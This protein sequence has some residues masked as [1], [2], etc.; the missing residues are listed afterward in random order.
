MEER[1]LL[2]AIVLSVAILFAWQYF[3]PSPERERITPEE[4]QTAETYTA[5]AESDV[6]GPEDEDVKETAVTSPEKVDRQFVKGDLEPIEVSGP[7]TVEVETDLYRCVFSTRGG[8]IRAFELKNFRKERDPKSDSVELVDPALSND[9]LPLGTEIM[10]G[11]KLLPVDAGFAVNTGNIDLVS[12]GSE[13]SAQLVMSLATRAGLEVKRRYTFKKGSYDLGFEIEISE[14]PVGTTEGYL[15]KAMPVETSV[16]WNV[17]VDPEKAKGRFAFYGT[18]L[19]MG[20]KFE[21]RRIAEIRKK[22]PFTYK[23]VGWGGFADAYFLSI[24]IPAEKGTSKLVAGIEEI[25][26]V[27]TITEELVLSAGEVTPNEKY[28][29]KLNIYLGPKDHKLLSNMGNGLEDAI[30]YGRLKS[31]VVPLIW[32]LRFFQKYVHNWGLAIILLTVFVKI[33]FFPLTR[34]S[35]ESMKAM[36]ALQPRIKELQEKYKD[37]R[38]KMN[39]EMMALYKAH[40]IN[41]VGGCLPMLLQLPVLYAL[42]RAIYVSIELRHSPFIWWINDLSAPEEIFAIPFFGGV[43]IGFMP[44]LMGASMYVQQKMTPTA[45]SDP[46]QAKMF[47]A[48]PVIFTFIS[49]GFPSGLVLYWFVSNLLTIVQQY[50]IN[51]RGI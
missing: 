39:S 49:F 11:G 16:M 27:E 12:E 13:D 32:I 43:E 19:K 42:Y 38:E 2:L 37:D 31:L 34:K 36:Q 35:Y 30:G 1:R 26:G 50:V 3:F 17:L 7:G 44:L 45:T 25:D 8:G 23:D 29:K 40:K 9:L 10:I 47:M 22:G 46:M 51:R 28:L 33:V 5:T 24:L 15:L 41:P 14:N 21:D 20:E 4:P 18:V 48:M 6:S